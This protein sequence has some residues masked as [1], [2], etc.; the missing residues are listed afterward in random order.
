MENLW[1]SNITWQDC[2]VILLLAIIAYFFYV[3]ACNTELLLDIE[4]WHSQDFTD[5]N[6]KLDYIVD[7]LEEPIETNFIIKQ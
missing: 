3:Q 6:N 5:I 2:L 4:E 1:K 7:K